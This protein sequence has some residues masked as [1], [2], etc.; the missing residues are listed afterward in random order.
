MFYEVLEGVSECDG[1]GLVRGRDWCSI[2][3]AFGFHRFWFGYK[4]NLIDLQLSGLSNDRRSC[5]NL[6]RVKDFLTLRAE[7]RRSLRWS[8]TS[9]LRRTPNSQDSIK[10]VNL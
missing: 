3:T 10:I 8:L 5:E 2:S 9:A 7:C 6:I 4:D 1:D